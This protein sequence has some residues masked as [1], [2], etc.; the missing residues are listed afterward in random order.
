MKVF[1]HLGAVLSGV[2]WHWHGCRS[3]ESQERKG[4][5]QH[6]SWSEPGFVALPRAFVSPSLPTTFVSD[7]GLLGNPVPANM[8][9]GRPNLLGSSPNRAYQPDPNHQPDPK[10]KKAR[11]PQ[12]YVTPQ[13]FRLVLEALGHYF[14]Y[15]WGTGT[16]QGP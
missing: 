9:P 7:P 10:T 3:S 11:Q 14:A 16:L 6:L 12:K 4:A 15:F 5:G 13:L 8:E 1:K 2:L